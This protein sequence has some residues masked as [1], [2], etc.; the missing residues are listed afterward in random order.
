VLFI[1]LTGGIGSGKSEA[2][3]ACERLGAAVL[4]SDAVVHDLLGTERVRNLLGERWGDRAVRSGD[5]DRGAVAQIVFADPQELAWLES[6]ISPLVGEIIAT[7]RAQLEREGKVDVAVVEVPLLFEAGIEDLFD[8]TIAIVADE[9]LRAER[10]GGRGHQGVE[11]REGRQLTQEDK[12]A[13]ADHLVRNDGTL[14]ELQ[15]Q[16]SIVLEQIK[17]RAAG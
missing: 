13:R 5:V 3:A 15:A 9:R 1:G 12:A 16:M 14:E 2:L 7:W 8:A 11:G 17:A 4:S 10:A 6:T